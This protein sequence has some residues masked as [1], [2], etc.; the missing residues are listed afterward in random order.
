MDMSR[1]LAKVTPP[2]MKYIVES[3]KTS[4]IFPYKSGCGK[5]L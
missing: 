4:E 1:T 3:F 2:K 5:R